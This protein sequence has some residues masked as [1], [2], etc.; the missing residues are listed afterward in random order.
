MGNP[1][2]GD[3][4]LYADLSTVRTVQL[5]DFR[6]HTKTSCRLA[7]CKLRLSSSITMRECTPRL[8]PSKSFSSPVRL[9]LCNNWTCCRSHLCGYD[10]NITYPQ[11][12]AIPN[13][14]PSP[15]RSPFWSTFRN[16]S[17]EL[18]LVYRR[19]APTRKRQSPSL[20][21]ELDPWYGCALFDEMIDYAA[22]F[23]AAW[24][25]RD[26]IDVRNQTHV[27]A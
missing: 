15:R 19:S 24:A 2:L 23:S 16:E 10:F 8:Y 4:S 25:A 22:N 13:L 21:N 6:R 9:T 3:V 17:Q 18:N 5:N 1:L 11:S 14:S 27:V 12:S 7:Y 20:G 26:A